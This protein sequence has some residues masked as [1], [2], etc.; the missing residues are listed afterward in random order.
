MA[1]YSANV[2]GAQNFHLE[3]LN[4]VQ[5]KKKL[6][7]NSSIVFEAAAAFFQY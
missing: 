4:T 1:L 7:L 2:D 5:E 6:A 3:S